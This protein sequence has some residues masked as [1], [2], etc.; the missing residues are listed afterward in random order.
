MGM[1]A[2]ATSKQSMYGKYAILCLQRV[3]DE[4]CLSVCNQEV[5]PSLWDT[6][7]RWPSLSHG[8][9]TSIPN[10]LA[11]GRAVSRGRVDL[12]GKRRGTMRGL[13]L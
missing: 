1:W 4:H 11:N 7:C 12:P 3:Y 6:M 8:I 5:H 2:G 10:A 13:T 9:C